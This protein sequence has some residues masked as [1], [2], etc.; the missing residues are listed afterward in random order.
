MTTYCEMVLEGCLGHA[1]AGSGAIAA[2]RAAQEAATATAR[3]T[4]ASTR[5]TVC[6]DDDC[7]A[8]VRRGE[9][10]APGSCRY[11]Q[12]WRG[13]T[14][15]EPSCPLECSGRG[16]CVAADGG[17][18]APICLCD[19]GWG[20][21]GAACGHYRLQFLLKVFFRG[22]AHLH[23]SLVC[24][25]LLLPLLRA[26]SRLTSAA[27][28]ALAAQYS[29]LERLGGGASGVDLLSTGTNSALL[30]VL[31]PSLRVDGRRALLELIRGV[32]LLT[33][34]AD[35]PPGRAIRFLD[36]LVAMLPQAVAMPRCA[37]EYFELLRHLMASEGGAALLSGDMAHGSM[38]KVLVSLLQS[39]LEPTTAMAR[40]RREERMPTLLHALLCVRGL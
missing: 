33:G 23:S 39:L 7:G 1:Q 24:E 31:P 22:M 18:A 26:V 6:A 8:L 16:K 30:G 34:L 19:S 10:V 20:G 12:G 15:S 25:R 13:V 29:A 37:A 28:A 35:H 14:C 27:A 40:F 9:C 5:F 11:L 21:G 17:G 3:A 2:S 38:P 4:V 32:A 36:L